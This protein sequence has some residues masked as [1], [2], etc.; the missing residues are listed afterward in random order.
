[1]K[2]LIS[3]QNNMIKMKG[4]S[5]H[6]FV[7]I[8]PLEFQRLYQENKVFVEELL[9]RCLSDDLLNYC[10][11]LPTYAQNADP[12]DFRSKVFETFCKRLQE[13]DGAIRYSILTELKKTANELARNRE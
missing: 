4:Y 3:S 13:S 5:R 1:M 7:T 9:I 8:T 2:D 6:E 12:F 11:Q 10:H